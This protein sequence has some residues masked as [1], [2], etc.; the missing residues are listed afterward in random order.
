MFQDPRSH[1][2]HRPH[3]NQK[4][5]TKMK[6]AEMTDESN[7]ECNV[8]KV[9]LLF[10]TRYEERYNPL[11]SSRSVHSLCQFRNY[12]RYCTRFVALEVSLRTL[13]NRTYNCH[14]ITV[15]SSTEVDSKHEC[16]GLAQGSETALKKSYN[17]IKSPQSNYVR[18][19]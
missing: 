12:S 7:D 6:P 9:H 14:L 2:L 19:T 17:S 16:T 1:D 15:P 4:M 18:H 13:A 3:E 11:W 10:V 8:T 5:K